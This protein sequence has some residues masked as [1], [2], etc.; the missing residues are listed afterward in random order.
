MAAHSRA[1]AGESTVSK[2][3]GLLEKKEAY[4][5]VTDTWGHALDCYEYRVV[6]FLLRM[7]VGYGRNTRAIGYNQMSKGIIDKDNPGA[8][9]TPPVNIG[10]TK[11]I[12]VL[13]RLK[14]RGIIRVKTGTAVTACE[15]FVNLEWI[16]DM[17]LAKPKRLQEDKKTSVPGWYES[18]IDLCRDTAQGVSPDGTGCVAP[19]YHKRR[20]VEDSRE[21]SYSAPIAAETSFENL[22]SEKTAD[23][24]ADVKTRS[25]ERVVQLVAKPDDKLNSTDFEKSWRFAFVETFPGVAHQAWTQKARG[26][27]NQMVRRWSGTRHDFMDFLDYAVRNWRRVMLER[28]AWMTDPPPLPDMSSFASGKTQDAFMAAYSMSKLRPDGFDYSEDADYKRHTLAGKT[29][30]EAIKQIGI[31]AGRQE[32]REE[33]KVGHKRAAESMIAEQDRRDKENAER[34][35][36]NRERA[37]DAEAARAATE[38]ASKELGPIDQAAADAADLFNFPKFKSEDWT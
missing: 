5:L 13:D 25:A 26:Q 4:D 35:V 23:A 7:S 1:Y 17:P 32:A 21:D 15:Y 3:I 2:A 10:R 31:D 8:W 28:L 30:D 24:F 9:F 34:A 29:H 6:M 11:L 16:P 37:A 22:K 18:S 14:Q 12:D 36:K 33:I 19:R 27:A 38:A 20:Q